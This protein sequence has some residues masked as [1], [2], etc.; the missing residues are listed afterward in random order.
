MASSALARFSIHMQHWTGS[1]FSSRCRRYGSGPELSRYLGFRRGLATPARDV[2]SMMDDIVAVR[3]PKAIDIF[4]WM[5]AFVPAVFVPMY[6]LSERSS[7]ATVPFAAF[8]RANQIDVTREMMEQFIHI[9]RLKALIEHYSAFARAWNDLP[10]IIRALPIGV[11]YANHVPS[12][13]GAISDAQLASL[14]VCGVGAAL[15]VVWKIPIPHLTRWLSRRLA[16]DRMDPA[17][18][19][20]GAWV[21]PLRSFVHLS[22]N[23]VAIALLG[24]LSCKW[25]EKRRAAVE[26]EP[27]G[28][29]EASQRYQLYA[30]I[31]TAGYVSTVLSA[32]Y[33][34]AVGF[35]QILRDLTTPRPPSRIAAFLSPRPE[36][37]MRAPPSVSFGATGIVYALA[38]HVALAVEEDE[39]GTWAHKFFPG[40]PGTMPVAL[41]GA[42]AFD[43]AGLVLGW[44]RFDHAAHIGG[45]LFGAVY[46]ARGFE[47]WDALYRKW[48]ESVY[49]AKADGLVRQV[50][51][52][53][54]KEEKEKEE[55]AKAKA[56]EEDKDI[57]G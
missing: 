39:E 30:F 36:N 40:W 6:F 22:A 1:A 49:D 8:S 37:P 34:R 18:K 50:R 24:E 28:R 17:W 25:M 47:T 21:S 46:Y 31:L 42:L 7:D 55:K 45:A 3:H 32:A 54:E 5:L 13:L 15:W 57:E 16:Y 43:V 14:K 53:E 12:F 9:L 2:G 44:R 4:P 29:S 41:S 19:R 48:W 33:F 52:L 51:L 20:V 10:N 35:R 27:G 23:C 11:I 56:K 38:A 26:K